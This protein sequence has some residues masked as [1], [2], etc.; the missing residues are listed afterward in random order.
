MKTSNVV[1]LVTSFFIAGS[2]YAKGP[3]HDT[4]D[5]WNRNPAQSVESKP[6]VISGEGIVR[7][8]GGC[9]GSSDGCSLQFVRS[10]DGKVFDLAKNPE[11]IALHCQNHARD[12]KVSLSGEKT[13]RFLF[14]GDNLKVSNFQV[15]GEVATASCLVK[16]PQH[17]NFSVNGGGRVR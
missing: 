9:Y 6:E 4:F 17:D 16:R 10:D 1:L 5:R 8:N 14:W 3:D 15:L 12:L 11:L 2:V 13:P 7:C